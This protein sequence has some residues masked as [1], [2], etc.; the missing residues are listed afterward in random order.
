MEDNR[1]PADADRG[2]DPDTTDATPERMNISHLCEAVNQMSSPTE[3][4]RSLSTLLVIVLLVIV[5]IIFFYR[6]A[7][8][9]ELL[10]SAFQAVSTLMN[11]TK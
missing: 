2:D 10:I 4:N 1:P 3:G 9:P 7:T 11:V 8:D 5:I 6:G